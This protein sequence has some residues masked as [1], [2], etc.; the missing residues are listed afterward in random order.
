MDLELR[1]A[2]AV[3]TGASRGI[4]LAVVRALVAEGAHV[5]AGART[6]SK[7]LAT[8]ADTGAVDVV[9]VDLAVPD[10]PAELVA[11]AGGRID[12]LVNNVGGVE[13]RLDGFL[14]ITDEQWSRSWTLN[15]MS[16]VRATRAALPSMLAAGRGA[17]VCV[18]SVNAFLPDPAVMDYCAGEAALENFAKALSKEVGPRGVRVN[19]VSPGPVATALWLGDDGVARTIGSST[20]RSPEDIAD[21][22]VA[23]TATGRFTRPDEV[24]DL[25]VLLAGARASNVTGTGVTIDGGLV[26]TL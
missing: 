3:V 14:A 22:A 10:G 19:C 8:L 6:S 5:V 11:A 20:G 12:V 26:A 21:A 2:V 1:D 4:G 13:P 18:G 16:A 24:A 15:L 7:E 17:I 23:T 25:V 9:P